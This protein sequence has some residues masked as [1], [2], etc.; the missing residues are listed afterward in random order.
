MGVW[1][2]GKRADFRARL[3]LL[4]YWL[5]SLGVSPITSLNLSESHLTDLQNEKATVTVMIRIVK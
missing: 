5:L 1:F 4:L 2:N 3:A